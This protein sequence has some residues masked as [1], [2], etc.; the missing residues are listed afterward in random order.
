MYSTVVHKGH[1]CLVLETKDKPRISYSEI[2][3][4]SEVYPRVKF[5][6]F[7]NIFH[8]R[9]NYTEDNSAAFVNKYLIGQYGHVTWRGVTCL[10]FGTLRHNQLA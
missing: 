6:R 2:R 9:G 3:G 5:W 10:S 4:Y 8:P 7:S 1:L